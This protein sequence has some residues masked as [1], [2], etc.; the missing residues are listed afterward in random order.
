MDPGRNR[1]SRPRLRSHGN[2]SRVLV[3]DQA[4]SEDHKNNPM[5][6]ETTRRSLPAKVE[7]KEAPVRASGNELSNLVRMRNSAIGKSAPSLSVHMREFNIP[8]RAAKAAQ[9]FVPI[10]GSPLESPRMSSSPHFAFAPIKRIGCGAGT[11][12][13]RRWSVASLPSSG[14]GTTPGSSNVSSQCSSQERLHQ[15]PNIPT[16]DEL[17]MLSCHFSK[18]GTPCSS[19]P[20]FPGSSI[21]S[22]PGSISFSL[23][24][25][26]RRSPLHRPRSRIVQA[27]RQCLT[28]KSL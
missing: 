22:I 20:G 10:V 26:G 12:D 25:E 19:H 8:R 18:P 9:P 27:D 7:S 16:K 1:P 4:E 17:R 24:E 15:L 21:S 13:G 28:M 6:P 5:E 23:E 2:P 3:F 11:A 14:Y